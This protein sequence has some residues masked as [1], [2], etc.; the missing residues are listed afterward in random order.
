MKGKRKPL[1]KQ[2]LEEQLK[3]SY[4]WATMTQKNV[5]KI[6][7]IFS[8][9]KNM[10]KQTKITPCKFEKLDTK[11]W[12]WCKTHDVG[13]NPLLWHGGKNFCPYACKCKSCE[14]I[15]ELLKVIHHENGK[16]ANS[17][18]LTMLKDLFKTWG[19]SVD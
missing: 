18:K 3:E 6:K 8:E 9:H 1:E 5:D 12:G 13:Y 11:D 16:K 14:M 10:K 17:I 2:T 19:M 7:Q 15:N 4:D